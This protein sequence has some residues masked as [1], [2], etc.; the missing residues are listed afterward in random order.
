MNLDVY[1]EYNYIYKA[2]FC[3]DP[4]YMSACIIRNAVVQC[5][6]WLGVDLSIFHHHAVVEVNGVETDYIQLF[7]SLVFGINSL[8]FWYRVECQHK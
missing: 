8:K 3:V 2:Q 4:M 7:V 5:V 1:C 6:C